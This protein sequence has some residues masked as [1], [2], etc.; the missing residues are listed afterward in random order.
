MDAGLPGV[1]LEAQPEAQP[2]GV[3]RRGNEPETIGKTGKSTISE[4]DVLPCE[5]RH[6]GRRPARQAPGAQLRRGALLGIT[7]SVPMQRDGEDR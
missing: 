2:Y 4:F 7:D 5:M 1:E 3:H 6:L